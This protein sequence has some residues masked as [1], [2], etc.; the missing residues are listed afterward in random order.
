MGFSLGGLQHLAVEAGVAILLDVFSHF[1]QCS[2]DVFNIR[3]VKL[4]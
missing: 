2:G 4:L 1:V 3:T